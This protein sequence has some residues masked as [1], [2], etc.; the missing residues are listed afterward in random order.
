MMALIHEDQDGLYLFAGGWKARP[1]D[2]LPGWDHVFRTDAAHLKRG[3]KVK[4]KHI[5]GTQCNKLTLDDGT[6]LVW[7]HDK[8]YS[9]FEKFRK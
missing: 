1:T 5:A 7:K 6:V 2:S 4:A 9:P 8:N 3:D